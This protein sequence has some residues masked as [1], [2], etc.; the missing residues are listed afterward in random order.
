MNT[1]SRYEHTS[2]I[3]QIGI[4][5][6]TIVI[7]VF[8]TIW[9][10]TSQYD[11]ALKSGSFDRPDPCLY[12]GDHKLSHSSETRVIYGFVFENESPI[13]AILP[14]ELRNEGKKSLKDV[15]ITITDITVNQ[16]SKT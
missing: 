16:K 15:S 4:F 2:L 9:A 6:A 10:I 13:T 8:L 12:F 1:F 3:V 11:V 5:I 7:T 14:L